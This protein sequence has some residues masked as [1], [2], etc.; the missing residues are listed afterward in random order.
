MNRLYSIRPNS[1][2]LYSEYLGSYSVR[3]SISIFLGI[4]PIAPG[5]GNVDPV[6]KLHTDYWLKWI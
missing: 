6:F 4:N 5:P 2:L 3:K 1:F